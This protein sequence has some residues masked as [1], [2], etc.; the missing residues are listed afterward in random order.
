[1]VQRQYSKKH[2]IVMYRMMQ[3]R[4][5]K[6]HRMV[7]LTHVQCYLITKQVSTKREDGS[8]SLF[9]AAHH[10]KAYTMTH[11]KCQKNRK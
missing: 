1:M 6:E 4:Y 8:E 3:Q 9:E 2:G 5:R 10:T 7:M 11:D